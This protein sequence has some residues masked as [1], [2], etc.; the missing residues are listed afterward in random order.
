MVEARILGVSTLTLCSF[1][2]YIL[3]ILASNYMSDLFV[4]LLVPLNHFLGGS[5][6]DV[7]ETLMSVPYAKALKCSLV[8]MDKRFF[9]MAYKVVV[10]TTH[11]F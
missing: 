1:D 6:S 10:T 8:L 5:L 9:N 4:F 2:S 7:S 3:R 11:S